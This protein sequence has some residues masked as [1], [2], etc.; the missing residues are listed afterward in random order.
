MT[1]IAPEALPG[2][3]WGRKSAPL[4][5]TPLSC[6]VNAPF[7]RFPHMIMMM[8][9]PTGLGGVDVVRDDGPGSSDR[10]VGRRKWTLLRS[11]CCYS[12]TNVE[13]GS[14]LS[15]SDCAVTFAE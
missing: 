1:P 7:A 5:R 15:S 2:L 4:R 8:P 3:A 10:A 13:M 14:F 9:W 6:A 12:D 11:W